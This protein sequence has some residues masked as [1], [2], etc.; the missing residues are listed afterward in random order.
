[1]ITGQKIHEAFN[2]VTV[3]AQSTKTWE[4]LSLNA[5][6]TYNKMAMHLN[7]LVGLPQPCPFCRFYE[8]DPRP[9]GSGCIGPVGAC[10]ECVVTNKAA[11]IT[12]L[13]LEWLEEQEG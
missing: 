7:E 2:L 1:M 10:D 13:L 11:D 12:E 4:E 5:R 6:S 8:I 3:N 9:V